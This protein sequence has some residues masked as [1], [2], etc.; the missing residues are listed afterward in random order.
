MM[1]RTRRLFAGFALALPLWLAGCASTSPADLAARAVL[2]PTGTLRV[3]VYQG[4]PTSMV[5]KPSG[6]TAGVAYELGHA[7][8]R[9]LGVPVRIIEFPRVQLVVDALKSGEAD[10]TFTNATEARARDVDFT[11][12]LVRLELGFLVLADSPLR[13]VTDMDRPGL[14]VGVS[15]GS[16]SQAA[17]PR[18]YKAMT[19]VPVPSLDA[20]QEQLRSKAADAFATNKAILYELNDQVPGLRVL[21]GRWGLEHLAIAVPKGRQAAAPY[22]RRFAQGQRDVGEV[23]KMMDRA[24]LRGAARD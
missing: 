10:L 21:E 18:L 5:R 4:S 11:E 1:D 17:L 20:V 22:L 13:S 24:G 7:L 6:E 14:K 19:L 9:E 8:A 15:Q 2:A 23:Q 3:A 12:P 16:S